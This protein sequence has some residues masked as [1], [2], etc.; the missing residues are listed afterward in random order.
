MKIRVSLV[1]LLV[2]ASLYAFAACADDPETKPT[3]AIDGAVAD[4]IGAVD[5]ADEDATPTVCPGNP[6]TTDGTTPTGGATV[7]A[8]PPVVRPLLTQDVDWFDG[9]VYTD[10]F[11]GA[12]VFSQVFSQRIVRTGPDG[13]PP[14]EL[15]ATMNADLLPIGNAQRGRSILTAIAPTQASGARLFQTFDDGGAGASLAT[16]NAGHPND[17]VV[18]DDGTVFFTDP[19][20]QLQTVNTGVYRISPSGDVTSVQ[21]FDASNNRANGIA[22]SPDQKALYVSF[23]DTKRIAKYALSSGQTAT[24]VAD[25]PVTLAEEPDGLAVDVSGNLWVAEAVA[26]TNPEAPENAGRVEVFAPDGTRWGAIVFPNHRVTGVAFGAEDNKAVYITAVQY[27][28][29]GVLGN[30]YAGS[31][32]VYVARCP[33][34]R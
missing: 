20:F 34:V 2:P 29:P 22:V 10:L 33:G 17:L 16:G 9:P 14:V 27:A 28:T 15:R 13:G 32:F 7:A 11:G 23:T 25:V 30:S 21:T 12:L 8:T 18:L 1:S 31:L 4:R 3:I 26:P 24:F 5:A 6:L 19:G